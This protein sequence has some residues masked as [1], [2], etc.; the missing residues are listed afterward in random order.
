MQNLVKSDYGDLLERLHRR[1]YVPRPPSQKRDIFLHKTFVAGTSHTEN[2]KDVYETIQLKD[3][4]RLCREPDNDFD[5]KAIRVETL[6]GNKI[7][8]VPRWD[9]PVLS[10][11]MDARKLLFAIVE[12]KSIKEP[13]RNFT[14][15]IYMHEE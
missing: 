2:I 4:V 5:E 13:Y 10:N 11:L 14:I 7:G 12:D 9:N 3:V 15:S 8:Y 6:D 1:G